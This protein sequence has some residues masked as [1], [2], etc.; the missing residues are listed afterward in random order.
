M[1]NHYASLRHLKFDRPGDKVLRITLDRA[2][3]WSKH[4][5]NKWLRMDGSSFDNSAALDILS[6]NDPELRE[7]LASLKEKRPPRFDFDV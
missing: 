4:A 7:G 3:S 5:L 6:F 1:P 2:E